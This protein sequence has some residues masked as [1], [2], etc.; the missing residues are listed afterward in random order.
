[1]EIVG[2]SASPVKK[3]VTKVTLEYAGKDSTEARIELH[4]DL[5]QH[6]K[7]H[8]AEGIKFLYETVIESVE[9]A[10]RESGGGAILAHC[11][12]NFQN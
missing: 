5:V 2:C 4:S 10:Q 8:Q 3:K 12:K 7:P 11:K 9:K 6:V 1:M